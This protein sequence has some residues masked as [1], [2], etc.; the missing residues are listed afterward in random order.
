MV[1]HPATGPAAISR[2]QLVHSTRGSFITC[3]VWPHLPR[4]GIKYTLD[5]PVYLPQAAR[6]AH[7]A[8]KAAPGN[9]ARSAAQLR[10][11]LTQ[12]VTRQLPAVRDFSQTYWNNVGGRW[13]GNKIRMHRGL[14]PRP[15]PR[16]PP[17]VVNRPLLP[18]PAAHRPAAAPGPAPM[19]A[20]PPRR[21]ARPVAQPAASS[22]QQALRRRLYRMSTNAAR[23]APDPA[24]QSP[25]APAGPPPPTAQP[26]PARRRTP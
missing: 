19:R 2:P 1:S 25:A 10:S 22:Q 26:A 18:A 8:V 4:L 16:T 15:H 21:S 5:A 24:P 23:R 3:P 6:A 13:A 20:R 11:R 17:R 12:P 14:P 9:L 7:T